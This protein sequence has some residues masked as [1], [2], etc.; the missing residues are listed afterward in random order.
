MDPVTLIVG[1]LAA[2]AAA[3]ATQTATQAVKD[4]YSGL[5]GLVQRHF[6]GNAKAEMILAEHEADPGTYEKPL[7]KALAESGATQD[8]AVV[9]QAQQLM[10]LVNPQQASQG[11]YNVQIG[12]GKGIAIGDGA[13]VNFG[14]DDE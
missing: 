8:E 10:T 1:A 12:T 6:K 2:G 3:G 9:Q 14:R 7:A 11:K 13:T 4:G 5:K